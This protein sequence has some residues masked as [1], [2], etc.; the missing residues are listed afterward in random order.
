MVTHNMHQALNSGNRTLMMDKG[1][2][3]L[4]VRDQERSGMT[5]DDLLENFAKVSGKN[6][7]NDRI[8]LS[9]NE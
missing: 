8:L 9:G 2:I 6:L 4:D 3:V 1:N 7:D 5:V